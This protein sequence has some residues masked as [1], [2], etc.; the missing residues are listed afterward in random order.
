MTIV[1]RILELISTPNKAWLRI[2]EENERVNEIQNKFL[3]PIILFV[4]LATIAGKLI[5]TSNYTPESVLKGAVI[6]LTSIFVGYFTAVIALSETVTSRS[7]EMKKQYTACV[8]I[9]AYSTSIMLCIEAL[10]ALVPIPGF[11]LLRVFNLYNVYIIWE[12]AGIIFKGLEEHK[13]GLFTVIC[14]ILLYLSPV[15][16]RTVMELMMR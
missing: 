5:N 1:K 8:R 4:T 15:L 2:R 3:F 14:V 9:I 10:V 13:K 12:G 16:V 6:I 11:F 7:F